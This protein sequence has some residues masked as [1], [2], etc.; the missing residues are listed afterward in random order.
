[1]GEVVGVDGCRGGWL[2]AEERSGVLRLRLFPTL[3]LVLAAYPNADVIAVDIP[4]GLA[5][6]PRYCDLEARTLLPGRKSCVF[7]PPCRH[8]FGRTTQLA[9]SAAMFACHG[10]KVT[11]QGFEILPKIEEVDRLLTP[12][13]QR[14]VREVHPELSFSAME[15]AP[16]AVK[17]KRVAGY[18]ARHAALQ[19]ALPDVPILPRLAYQHTLSGA[20]PDDVL[21]AAAALWTAKRIDRGVARCIPAAPPFDS[22][23]LRMEMWI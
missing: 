20:A 16:I 7:P 8:A 11:A 5:C 23:G 18:V 10:K 22:R 9:A 21:D 12:D 14:V 15:G 13:L 17:K 6:G 4:V 3:A 19:A 2:A 1:M